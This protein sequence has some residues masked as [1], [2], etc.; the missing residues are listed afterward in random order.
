MRG[1]GALGGSEEHV[2][3]AWTTTTRILVHERCEGDRPSVNAFL[4]PEIRFNIFARIALVSL[5]KTLE[6]FGVG[7]GQ[8]HTSGG[9]RRVR[10]ST[11]VL[12]S[13]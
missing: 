4:H 11:R 13:G 3:F 1:L 8:D 10:V 2:L 6:D 12:E 9:L 7:V 5:D